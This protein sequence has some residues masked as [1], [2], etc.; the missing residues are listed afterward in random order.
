MRVHASRVDD[1]PG[2][3]AVVLAADLDPVTEAQRAYLSGVFPLAILAVSLASVAGWL[4]SR[5]A[6]RPV[7]RMA[8]EAAEIGGGDLSR[9]LAVSATPDE[10]SHL[11]RTLND[12]LQRLQDSVQRER[13][14]TADASHEIRTPLA[15]MRAELEISL[16]HADDTDA[17][18]AMVSAL[19]ECDRLQDLTED[20]LLIARA[21]AIQLDLRE[22]LDLGDLTDIVLVRLRALAEHDR[23]V[24]TRT[25]D[26]V[27][28]ADSR[29]ME[30]A[31]T[32]LVK[33]ALQHVGRGGRVHV[34]IDPDL[35]PGTS[36][37]ALQAF[38]VEPRG[39]LEPGFVRWRV[40]DDGPGIPPED[41]D[42]L[43]R[44]FARADHA[45]V[46]A[47][48]GLGLA[49]VEAVVRGHGG[50]MSLD[51]SSGGGLQV[52]LTLPAGRPMA[53]QD[54]IA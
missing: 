39:S 51:T 38:G 12:M 49:I 21:E 48:A 17:R 3:A 45:R 44:R 37:Q 14:F 19:E 9:R 47:G 15:I 4:V 28:L 8:Q 1:I 5:R 42:R 34:T 41:R 11:G 24:L 30:R 23:I 7:D 32:N 31:L 18:N 25:G 52:T 2:V 50:R 20:L 54:V 27:I 6:L 46:V 33:N 35:D 10:L 13:D 29:A 43:I 53:S 40:A 26:A 16:Q 36:A 22:P